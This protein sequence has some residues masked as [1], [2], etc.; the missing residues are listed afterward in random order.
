ML[1][2]THKIVSKAEGRVRRLDEVSPSEEARRLAAETEMDP[3]LVHLILG[4][5][6]EV[7]R[8]KRGLLIVEHRL[9]IIMANAG[10]DQ[11]NVQEGCVVLLPVDPDHSALALRQYFWERFRKRIGVILSD[12]VGRAWR[13]GLCGSCYRSCGARPRRC[14]RGCQI[15]SAAPASD[16]DRCCGCDCRRRDIGD[17]RVRRVPARCPGSRRPFHKRACWC[18]CVATSKAGRSLSMTVS[19]VV[20][21]GGVGGAKLALGLARLGLEEQLGIVANTG[22]DFEHLGLYVSPDV[23]TLLYTLSGVCNTET[24]WGRAEETWACMSELEALGGETW[25][26]LGDRDLATHLFRTARLREGVR[27]TAVS[28]E[29]RQRFGVAPLCRGP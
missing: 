19:F 9:G 3:R 24:G 6:V 8:K 26:R 27:L 15:D 18:S 10:I 12:S 21:S 29:L 17:G 11:S 4:E 13:L 2:V 14:M 7:L 23:D 20:F 5:S 25:F 28:E 22:D 1:V 16:R